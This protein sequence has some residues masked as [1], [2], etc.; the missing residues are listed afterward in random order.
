MNESLHYLEKLADRARQE[1]APQADVSRRVLH[2]LPEQKNH[3]AAPMLVFAAGYAAIASLAI[4]YGVTLL[5]TANDPL[6]SVF[7]LALVILP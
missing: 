3:L 4:T 2:R 6:A 5:C 1:C 7:Q